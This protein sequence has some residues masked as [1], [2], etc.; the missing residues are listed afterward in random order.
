MRRLSPLPLGAAVFLIPGLLRADGFGLCTGTEP[1]PCR[2]P[3]FRFAPLALEGGSAEPAASALSVEPID[4]SKR[5]GL[6]RDSALLF[7]GSLAATPFIWWHPVRDLPFHTRAEGWFDPDT[8]AGG[9]DKTSHFVGSY[10]GFRAA[11]KANRA[12][13]NR[14]R[15][16]RALAFANVSLMGVLI[17]IGDAKTLYGFSWEDVA[18]DL[19]G[20]LTGVVVSALK[21]EDTV[22]F[23]I[24]TVPYSK[25]I[26]PGDRSGSYSREIYAGDLRLAGFLP[27]VGLAPGPARYFLLSVTYAV[28]GYQS[29]PP[30]QRERLLGIEVGLNLAEVARALGVSG[31]RWW[32]EAVFFVLESFRFPYTALGFR[33]DVTGRRWVSPDSGQR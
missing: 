26:D 16:A 31:T 33:Y 29:L 20:T 12:L 18:A 6:L 27:R 23:R 24:G 13:G 14:D 22:G 1:K 11:E 32:H 3:L 30:S 19:A 2:D 7:A 15:T 5:P 4:R 8:Y 17:E 25:P 10:I 9:A 21:L 28:R